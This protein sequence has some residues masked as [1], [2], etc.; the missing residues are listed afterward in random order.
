MFHKLAT[1]TSNAVVNR[2]GVVVL[3]VVLLTA[4]V[5]AGIA[6]LDNG[7]ADGHRR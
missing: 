2:P 1:K 4:L 7:R 6:H 3:V 5:G